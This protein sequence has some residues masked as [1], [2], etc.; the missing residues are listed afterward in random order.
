MAIVKKTLQEQQTN[1]YA[2]TVD[3]FVDI[4]TLPVMPEIGGGSSAFVIN[5]SSVY[6][7][8]SS[9]WREI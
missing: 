9:G 5:T 3:D 2:F 7:L 4:A 8:G 1:T 6:L